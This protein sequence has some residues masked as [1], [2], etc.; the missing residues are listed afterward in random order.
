MKKV[1]DSAKRH[2]LLRKEIRLFWTRVNHQLI[3]QEI[4]HMKNL[5]VI[6]NAINIAND[7]LNTEIAVILIG[8]SL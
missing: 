4:R 2:N 3:G 6:T 8:G 7:L 1:E 5:T